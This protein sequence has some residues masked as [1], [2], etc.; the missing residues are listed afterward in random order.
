LGGGLAFSMLWRFA[1]GASALSGLSLAVG[2]ALARGLAAFTG[3][4]IALKWPND[5]VAGGGKLGGILIE[6]AGDVLGPGAAVIGVGINVQLSAG[7]RAAID[8]PA[9]DLESLLDGRA[10]QSNSCISPLHVAP[11]RVAGGR[12]PG[13]RGPCSALDAPVDRNTLLAGLLV[14]LDRA[15]TVFAIEGFA[16]FHSEWELRHAHQGKPVT[17][18]LPDGRSEQGQANGVAE[19]GSLVLQ[20]PAGSG[21]STVERSASALM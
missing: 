1:Q 14:E 17:V 8:Q 4:A 12:I 21:A 7:V 6:L 15:L 11:Q 13:N 3:S 9:A 2:V 10:L 20:T 16:P 18:L 5:I 19:D